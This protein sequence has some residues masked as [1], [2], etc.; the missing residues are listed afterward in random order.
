MMDDVK[1]TV[2][3]KCEIC[4][5]TPAIREDGSTNYLI[6]VG[7]GKFVCLDC[8][9]Q[10]S[11]SINDLSDY[12]SRI[13]Q[14][15]AEVTFNPS[16]IMGQDVKAT[17]SRIK[18][19]LDDYIIGQ[20]RAKR[21]LSTAI[22][23]HQ[24]IN[25]LR[26]TSPE[27][28]KD[29]EK[30]NVIL[31][32]PSGCGKTALIKRIAK[33]M[34]IPIVI[35]DITSFSSTGYVGKDVEA[36]CRDLYQAA[37]GDL[38]LAQK[39]IIY[40]DEIDK[41]SRKGESASVSSDPNHEDLQFALLKLIEGC[42]VEVCEKGLRHH[43]QAPTFKMNT[44]NIL[45]I[46]GGAFEGIE[47]IIAQRQKSAGSSIG[48]GS[49]ITLDENKA[50]NDFIMDV[51]TEDLKKYGLM[52]ELLGR[53]PLICP[54]TQLDEEALVKILTEPKNS[55]AKQFIS[56]FSLSGKGLD[57]SEEA[58]KV[59]AHKAIER[60]TGARS[61]RGIVTE[62]LSDIMYKLPDEADDKDLI[63]YLVDAKDGKLEVY[64]VTDDENMQLV[65]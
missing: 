17:P 52:P 3:C 54:M 8:Y 44:E 25:N 57:F 42:D 33:S 22:Y 29:V 40:I 46:V 10:I 1:T 43:P 2:E 18:A 16:G 32:G 39:G 35:E 19:E 64:R 45:F 50:F 26:E 38:E 36:M 13:V 47:K 41:C 48:F 27:L 28:V 23:N 24:L 34:N 63:G 56:I 61:L 62:L 55:I 4:G 14:N 31:L 60:K 15:S 59:I 49:K 12:Q 53:L 20:E 30:S 65:A 37:N 58:C 6:E 21:V 11:S 5:K 51:K 9:K 7:D